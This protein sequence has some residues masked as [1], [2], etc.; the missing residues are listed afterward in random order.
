MN[1]VD[2]IFIWLK[3]NFATILGLGQA[4]LKAVKEILTGVINLLS[5][6][7]PNKTATRVVAN[8]RAS[9]NSVDAIFEE[10]KKSILKGIV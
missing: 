5:I 7:V 1:I 10:W 8:I 4:G 2:K 9:V 6:F 3:V